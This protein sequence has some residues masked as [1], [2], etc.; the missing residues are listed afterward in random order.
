VILITGTTAKF[1]KLVIDFLLEKGA[2]LGT[3]AALVRDREKAVD[4]LSKGIIVRI[5]D[6]NSYASLVDAFQRVDKLLLL[7]G[8]DPGNHG[9]Q[10][11]NAIKAAKEAGVRHIFYT[12]CGRKNGTENSSSDFL[13]QTHDNTGK[14]IKES[15]IPYTILRNNVYTA[16]M[17]PFYL[18]ESFPGAGL[19]FPAGQT[20]AA[21]PLH[22]GMAEATAIVLMN[23]GHENKEYFFSNTE[24]VACDKSST[25]MQTILKN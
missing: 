13:V 15:G 18:D 25:S 11:E 8:A 3:I 21:F 4:F 5:G 23:A 20:S 6:Y 12:S 17:L 1:G 16:A 7:S 9:K 10:H 2:P 14:A 22:C 19:V 24:N